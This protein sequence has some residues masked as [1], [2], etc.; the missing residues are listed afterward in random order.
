MANG[1]IEGENRTRIRLPKLFL[2]LVSLVHSNWRFKADSCAIR[3]RL[4]ANRS[5]CAATAM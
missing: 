4:L 5:R 2:S 1:M 3:W